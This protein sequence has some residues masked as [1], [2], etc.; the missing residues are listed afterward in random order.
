M[1]Q[2]LADEPDLVPYK[3]MILHNAQHRDDGQGIQEV[4]F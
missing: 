2:Y 3:E 4:C 1:L